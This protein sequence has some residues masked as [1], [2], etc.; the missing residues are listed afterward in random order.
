MMKYEYSKG[1]EIV[2]FFERTALNLHYRKIVYAGTENI[3]AGSPVIFASNHRNAVIDPFLLLNACKKQ[4]VFLAR[5]DVFKKPAVARI[6]TWLHIM[7]V[8]RIRDGVENLENNN[9][10]FQLSGELLKKRIP[11]ALY[12]EGKH[13]PRMSL[14]PVQ[15]AIS[16]I[17][18]PIE[19]SENFALGS[20]VVPVGV[21]YPDIFGF[22]S[23]A[24]MVFGKPIKV[25]DY[26]E[27]YEEN[28]N[29]AA[30]YLRR[31]LEERMKELTIHIGNDAFYDEYAH[32]IDWN[33]SRLATEKYADKREG[34]LLASQE[35]VR[36][37]DHLFHNNRAAF[38]AK[39]ADFREAHRIVK[40]RGFTSKDNIQKPSSTM[41]L[42]GQL[43]LL[44]VSLP[45]AIFGFVNGIFPILVYK[46]LLTLFKDNQFIPTV[47]VV[48]GMF[49]VPAFV[50][51]QSL[52]VCLVFG[53]LWASAYFVLMPATF[54]F[55]C[56]WRKWAKSLGRKWR[57]NRFVKKFPEEWKKFGELIR[58]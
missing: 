1:Y 43:L 23:D 26:R 6:M 38:D 19:A 36:R 28:P 20:E 51:L 18:L 25:A 35:V 30:N 41:A 37:L 11:M 4:P 54:Y 2:R 50:L 14:L 16:R 10:S 7:P 32:A 47:R 34:F 24:Y 5:A 58:L 55:A 22:L 53:W 42:I 39:M 29:L 56:W 3:N 49:V 13:N 40:N 33:A 8:Y 9:A 17:V 27:Q 15:K 45:A 52:I 46:K 12:P 44:I 48:S 57:V 31:E 21:Y